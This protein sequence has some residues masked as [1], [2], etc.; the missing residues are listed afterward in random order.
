MLSGLWSKILEFIRPFM[1]SPLNR[2]VRRTKGIL[3]ERG[4]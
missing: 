1:K 3:L 4:K 2:V